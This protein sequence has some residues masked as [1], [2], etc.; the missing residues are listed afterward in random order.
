MVP[1]LLIVAI[2]WINNAT[3]ESTDAQSV[4]AWLLMPTLYQ[5]IVQNTFIRVS[6]ILK[7]M[8]AGWT[9]YRSKAER[10][11]YFDILFTESP[12]Q[13]VF[14]C[15]QKFGIDI[16]LCAI[17]KRCKRSAKRVKRAFSVMRFVQCSIINSRSYQP[18]AYLIQLQILYYDLHLLSNTES[19]L[20]TEIGIEILQCT[21]PPGY[22]FVYMPMEGRRGGVVGLT[23]Q[24]WLPPVKSSSRLVWIHQSGH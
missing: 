23:I 7:R 9:F 2:Q 21:G 19:R 11:I 1:S 8:L 4:T 17:T 14:V 18:N 10:K 6:W 20:H 12:T 22:T 13:F 5:L 24:V 16:G 15:K 3:R